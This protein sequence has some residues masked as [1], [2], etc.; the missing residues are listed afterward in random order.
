MAL[1]VLSI[2]G[3]AFFRHIFSLCP[4]CRIKAKRL[5]LRLALSSNITPLCSVVSRKVFAFFTLKMNVFY[6]KF[7]VIIFLVCLCID[8]D[9]LSQE[10]LPY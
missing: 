3:I 1:V 6:K 7:L 2:Y 4:P 10:Y 5:I 9:N 8:S